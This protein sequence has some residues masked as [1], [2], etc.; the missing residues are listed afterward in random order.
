MNAAASTGDPHW[1]HR[2]VRRIL[3]RAGVSVIQRAKWCTTSV[4]L[5]DLRL[6]W[7]ELWDALSGVTQDDELDGY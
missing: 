2:N 6:D 7:P 5:S 3:E 4:L 1:R